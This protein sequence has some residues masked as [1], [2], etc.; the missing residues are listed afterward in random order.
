M[1]LAIKRISSLSS[2]KHKNTGE[3]TFKNSILPSAVLH[4]VSKKHCLS[5][6]LNVR[7]ACDVTVHFLTRDYDTKLNTQWKMQN[8]ST[9][10]CWVSGTNADCVWL[11]VVGLNMAKYVNELPIVTKKCKV[12]HRQH[13]IMKNPDVFSRFSSRAKN[14]VTAKIF[15]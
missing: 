11:P 4:Q 6:S 10:L 15:N 12:L 13:Q 3:E 2:W 14:T 5:L 1:Y 9:F 8:T 7:S